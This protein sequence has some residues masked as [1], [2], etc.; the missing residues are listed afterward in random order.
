MDP[1]EARL[2][3][4][5]WFTEPKPYMAGALSAR[6]AAPVLD[7]AVE[8]FVSGMAHLGAW[9]GVLSLRF[10][11]RASGQ[12]SFLILADTLVPLEEG[13]NEK[14]VQALVRKCFSG[15]RFPA[16]RAA[17]QITLPLLFR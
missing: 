7:E 17:T 9:H 1:R 5:G 3:L 2:V 12:S 16:A 8:T 14:A 10:S 4:H 6:K 11:V 15:L 13:S